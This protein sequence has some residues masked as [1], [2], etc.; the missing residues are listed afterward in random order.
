MHKLKLA[1]HG[2]RSGPRRQSV[3]P[4]AAGKLVYISRLYLGYARATLSVDRH[5]NS[6]KPYRKG[7]FNMY[8]VLKSDNCAVRYGE[9][10]RTSS[11]PSA[12]AGCPRPLE[13][14]SMDMANGR[15][16][17]DRSVCHIE[18]EM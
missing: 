4:L 18:T 10:A 14:I 9:A 16:L 11:N 12:L 3:I 2:G 5:Y 6:L 15:P 17:P 8:A 13:V 1:T 7:E